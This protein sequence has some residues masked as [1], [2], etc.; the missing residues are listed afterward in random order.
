MRLQHARDTFTIKT[1]NTTY[2]IKIKDAHK[3]GR[4]MPEGDCVFC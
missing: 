4:I 1:N 2:K 3:Q